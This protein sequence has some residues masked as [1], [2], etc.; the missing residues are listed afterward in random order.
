LEAF[1]AD[2]EQPQIPIE[3]SCVKSGSLLEFWETK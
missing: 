1:L 2:T 3:K